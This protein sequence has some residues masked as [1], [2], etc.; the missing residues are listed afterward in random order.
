MDK[1]QQLEVALQMAIQQRNSAQDQILNLGVQL[2]IANR[3][4]K[5]LKDQAKEQTPDQEPSH[6]D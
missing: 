6:K 1:T 2:E 3:E 5:A 4:I